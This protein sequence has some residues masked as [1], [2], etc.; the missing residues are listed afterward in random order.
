[1]FHNLIRSGQLLA[2]MDNLVVATNLVEEMSRLKTVM[3]VMARSSPN[4]NF[5]NVSSFT[6]PLDL[7]MISVTISVCPSE[8]KITAAKHFPLPK[9]LKSVQSFLGLTGYFWRFV[10]EYSLIAKPLSDL[11]KQGAVFQM[12]MEHE[13]AVNQLKKC[14]AQ[15]YEYITRK[16]E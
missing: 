14:L 5:Q 13:T 8:E 7:D 6:D 1:M 9:N 15:C 12:G 10:H 3:H 11:L 2:Y 4:I 16:P